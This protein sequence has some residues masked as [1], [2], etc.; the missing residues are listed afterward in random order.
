MRGQYWF[1]H[2][3]AVDPADE[4]RVVMGGVS[5]YTYTSNDLTTGGT[6]SGFASGVHADVHDIK[7]DPSN[8]N[9]IYIACDGGMYKTENGSSFT[10]INGG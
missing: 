4:D 6:K 10:N 5:Y 8:S 7:F 2:D 9:I 3:V 1:A